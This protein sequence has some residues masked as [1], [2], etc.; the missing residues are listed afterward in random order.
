M[1]F[2]RLLEYLQDVVIAI[3]RC[4]KSNYQTYVLFYY[5]TG[6]EMLPTAGAM[7]TSGKLNQN[8]CE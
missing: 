1:K 6:I 2:G 4:I 7:S 3:L 8:H 5:V